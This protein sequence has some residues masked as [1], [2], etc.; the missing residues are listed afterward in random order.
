MINLAHIQI[1]IAVIESGG[2]IAA[3]EVMHLSQP[4]I[5]NA[6]KKLEYR[7][8]FAL[9]DRTHYRPK[10]TEKGEA[11]YQKALELFNQSTQLEQ[12]VETLRTGIEVQF[13]IDLDIGLPLTVYAPLI[14]SFIKTYPKTCF[15]LSNNSFV[16]CLERLKRKECNISIAASNKGDPNMDYLPMPSIRMLPVTSKVY[17]EEH[18]EQINNPKQDRHCMQIMIANTQEE[19]HQLNIE[20][21]SESMPKWLVSDMFT[22]KLL[23]L[24]GMGIGRLPDHLIAQELEDGTLIQLNT[25]NYL[26][27]NM[28]IYAMRLINREHGI[29]SNHAWQVLKKFSEQTQAMV[30]SPANHAIKVAMAAIQSKRSPY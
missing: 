28:A 23:I 10:L 15:S 30:I 18:K 29:V 17:Y 13:S 22:R 11:F 1:F 3:G 7:L 6:I 20:P 8:G 9:F 27:V 5:T 25:K 21:L 24:S 26:A 19:L 4:S 12:H 16:T 2:F 14:Q